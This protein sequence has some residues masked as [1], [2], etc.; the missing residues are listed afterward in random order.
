MVRMLSNVITE[1]R[2]LKQHT[3][4]C[5]AKAKMI[6][7]CKEMMRY[8]CVLVYLLMNVFFDNLGGPFDLMSRRMVSANNKK[9]ADRIIKEIE[10]FDV[11]RDDAPV[12]KKE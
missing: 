1:R 7:Y 3:V 4:E 8:K 5:K 9:I 12:Q 11:T 10:A 2:V 6:N